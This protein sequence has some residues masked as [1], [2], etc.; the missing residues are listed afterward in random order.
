MAT[1]RNTSPT[2]NV[3]AGVLQPV[4]KWIPP[5]IY[6]K[7]HVAGMSFYTARNHSQVD[8]I[9]FHSGGTF[10]TNFAHDKLTL[11]EVA[12]MVYA[13]AYY[14]DSLYLCNDVSRAAPAGYGC[15]LHVWP[16]RGDLSDFWSIYQKLDTSGSYKTKNQHDIDTPQHAYNRAM[17]VIGKKHVK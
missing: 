10:V 4:Y 7:S 12:L 5:L 15:S 6:P 8:W 13:G 14:D 3:G 11:Y 16:Y 1:V 9:S 2:P 17:G